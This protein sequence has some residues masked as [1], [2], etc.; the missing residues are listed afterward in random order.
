MILAA[1]SAAIG[2]MAWYDRQLTD[3]Q[4]NVAT[5]VIR[6]T[7]PDLYSHDPVF[8]S[9]GL[10]QFN[11]PAWQWYLQQVYRASG[12][13]DKPADQWTSDDVLP[14]FRILVGPLTLIYLAGMYLLLWQQ[15]RS[16]SVACYTAILSMAMIFVPGGSFWGLGPLSSMAPSTVVMVFIPLLV[17]AMLRWSNSP[18]ILW[19][20]FAA[21]L[22]ANVQAVTGMNFA[23]VLALTYLGYQ[24]WRP[25]AWGMALLGGLIALAAASPYLWHFASLRLALSTGSAANWPA[26]ALAF[27]QGDITVL[28]PAMLDDALEFLAYTLVLWIPA[29]V[30]ILRAERF[31]VQNFRVWVWMLAAC[32]TVG[33]VLH[34][35]SQVAGILRGSP[36]PVIDFVHALR[37][38]LLPLYVLFAQAIVHL[39]RLGVA[40]RMMQISLGALMV[41]WMM[42]AINLKMPRQWIEDTVASRMAEDSRPESVQTRK[43][44]RQREGEMRAITDWLRTQTPRDTVVA[45][46]DL[47]LRLWAQRSLVANRADVKYIYYLAP[48]QLKAWSDLVEAQ[49]RALMPRLGQP[50]DL[51][52]I[53]RFAWE[54]AAN[55]VVL[56]GADPSADADSRLW[57]QPPDSAWGAY[58]RLYRV[59]TPGSPEALRATTTSTTSSPDTRD[60]SR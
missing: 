22:L 16:W 45:C 3:E 47:R 26:V 10:W 13:A 50:A 55:Y 60:T 24:R 1:V 58:W 49:R 46:Q 30:V 44:R 41:V 54:H 17:W 33:L 23:L 32:L 2:T 21:G 59:P 48:G 56:Q 31:R 27:Q 57:V 11:S 42:L 51:A 37:F 18:A 29:V 25:R 9:S 6:A 34:G 15:C 12:A 36:P 28:Y 38:M 43:I 53:T 4:V 20:F 35:L 14:A 19:V 40:G 5:N 7:Q 39:V 52:E 8:G